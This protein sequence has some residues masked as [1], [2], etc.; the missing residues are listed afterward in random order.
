MRKAAPLLWSAVLIGAI[1]GFGPTAP[2]GSAPALPERPGAERGDPG[3]RTGAIV[4]QVVFTRQANAGKAIGQIEKGSR[5]VLA[6]GTS[7]PT[8]YRQLRKSRRATFDLSYGSSAELTLNPAGPEFAD[9]GLNPFAVPAIREAVNWLVDRQYI[10]SELY[11]GLAAPRW[12]PLSTAFPDYARLAGVA[13]KLELRY[14][15]QP[16]KAARVIARE[17]RALGAERVDGQWRYNGEPVTLKFLIRTEDARKQ[18]GDYV[19]NQFADLGF[20]IQRMYRTAE[21]ASPMWIAS[22]PAAGRWHVYTGGWVSTVINRDEAQNLAGYYTPAG[23]PFPLWQAYEPREKLARI[24]KKLE[25]RD[26]ATWDERQQLMRRG[27]ELAMQNSARV[28]L[29]DQLNAWPRAKDVRLATDLA[30]GIAG[31]QLW[32]FTLRYQNRVGGEM[33]MAAPNVL[34]EPWNPI[35]GTNWIFDQMIMRGL[36]DSPLLPDPYTGL[37]RPQRVAS[38]TVTVQKGTPVQRTLDWL[39]LETREQIRV[40]DDAWVD[41]DAEAKRFVSAAERED[42]KRTART[43]V[44]VRYE[45]GYLDRQWHDGTAMALADLVLPYILRF[46][47]ADEDSALFDTSHV[48]QHKTFERHFRGWR[49]VSREPLVVEIYSDQIYP[50]AETIVAA[51]TPG[52]TPWHMLALGIRAERSGELAFSSDK[53]D[54]NQIPWLSLVSGPSLPVL[55]RH[56]QEAAADGWVPFAAM[57]APYMPDGSAK[58][59]YKALAEWR[60]ERGHYW[61]GAGPFYLEALHPVEGTL[62]LQ[63]YEDFPDNSDKWIMEGRTTIPDVTIEGPMTVALDEPAEFTVDIAA[64]GAP[65]PPEAVAEVEYLLLDGTGA[66]VDRGPVRHGDDG[67]WTL[68]LARERIAALGAGANRLEVIVTSNRVA[69]PRFASHAFATIPAG[70]GDQP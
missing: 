5:A 18:V 3:E 27:L 46:A 31:S 67:E 37:Y 33:I 19:A 24:A 1:A 8:L 53:A 43:R 20:R 7:D 45:D 66:L 47:R 23:R 70:Q 57:L 44:R 11:G 21:Q 41:W 12:L 13:R 68:E 17:M 50:D 15:H 16:E 59:R 48:P 39:S 65:Y 36:Q 51:R 28:W 22:D 14:S 9:G 4:D 52:M 32:P 62:V 29:V 2:A 55:D 61:V 63:R 40:P 64:A 10:A 58:R 25:Q 6:Q 26:Y 56:R 42:A 49:I 54:R 60:A 69:L 35:A 30:G 38:A 34:T